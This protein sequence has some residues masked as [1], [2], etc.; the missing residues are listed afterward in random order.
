MFEDW[1][2]APIEEP[3]R[4]ALG[5][6]EALTLAPVE[7]GPEMIEP[8]R[9]QGLTDRDIE[10]VSVICALFNVIVRLADTLEFDV[11]TPEAFEKFAPMMLKRG[12]K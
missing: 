6:I 3:L 10:D 4:A 12:Y 9:A 2:T 11:P 1:R 8:L 7:V 5:F